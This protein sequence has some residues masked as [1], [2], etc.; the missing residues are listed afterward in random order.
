MK[1]NTQE[2][3]R[4]SRRVDLLCQSAGARPKGSECGSEVSGKFCGR[5]GLG[6]VR[7]QLNCRVK[8]FVLL[9]LVP[10]T[11]SY[12]SPKDSYLGIRL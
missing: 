11:F 1:S 5:P 4:H 3:R 7:A 2:G 12:T 10:E 6:A 8:C 9:L